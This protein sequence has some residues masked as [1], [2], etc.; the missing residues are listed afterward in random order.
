MSL[1][2]PRRGLTAVDLSLIA[3]FAALIAALGLPGALT[4]GG[5]VPITLQTLGVMLAGSVL[6]WRRGMLAVI[7]FLA[8]VAV[9]LP[10]LAGGAEAGS[11]FSWARV[12]DTSLVGLSGR[13]SLAGLLSAT[14]HP[15]PPG[16]SLWRM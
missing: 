11:L 6:G 12:R 9:G 4:V 3:S 2:S 7:T 13:E 15:S 14:D 5:T 8:L 16:G 1:E 10:L